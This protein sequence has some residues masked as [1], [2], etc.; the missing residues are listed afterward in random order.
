MWYFDVT[1]SKPITCSKNVNWSEIFNNVKYFVFISGKPEILPRTNQV[2]FGNYNDLTT[3]KIYV[4]SIPPL[5]DIKIIRNESLIE[6]S[7]LLTKTY[8]FIKEN[9]FGK[10]VLI[11][12]YTISLQI[13]TAVARDFGNYTFLLFNAKGSQAF[14]T[15]LTFNGK[16]EEHLN[17]KILQN[18][19]K[20]TL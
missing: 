12:G 20:L 16:T 13:P 17:C 10:D 15:Q 5:S 9:I 1:V 4:Y 8:H 7:R 19:W 2:Q 14:T 3:L 18:R 6:K 11:K